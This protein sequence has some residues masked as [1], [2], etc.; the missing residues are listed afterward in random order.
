MSLD[1]SLTPTRDRGV[2]SPERSMSCSNRTRVSALVRMRRMRLAMIQP[3]SSTAS[4]A[5]VDFEEAGPGDP[6]LDVG[7]F[8]AHLCWRSRFGRQKDADAN[9]SYRDEFRSAAVDRFGWPERDLDPREAVCL[10]R[11]CTNAIRNPK[12]DWRAKLE[13][14]LALVEE[15]LG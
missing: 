11:I 14:G 10:F 3:T 13:A 9:A 6:M 4:A 1:G 5:L 15:T 8:I 2:L 7:N 12:D